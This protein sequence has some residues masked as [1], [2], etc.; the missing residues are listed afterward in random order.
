MEE[1]IGVKPRCDAGKDSFHR[2]CW[3]FMKVGKMGSQTG[4]RVMKEEAH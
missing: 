3:V 4:W 1:L 2:R